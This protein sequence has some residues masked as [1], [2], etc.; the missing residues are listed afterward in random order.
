MELDVD[1]ADHGLDGAFYGLDAGTERAGLLLGE[2]VERRRQHNRSRRRRMGEEEVI[3][4]L[5]LIRLH[6]M[7]QTCMKCARNVIDTSRGY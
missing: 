5:F 1:G 7:I 6:A 2:V 4:P 3:Q